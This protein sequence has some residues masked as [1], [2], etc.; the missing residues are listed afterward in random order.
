MSMNKWEDAKIV[1][2]LMKDNG[3][4]KMPASSIVEI[5]GMMNEFLIG[6]KYHPNS[7]ERYRGLKR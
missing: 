4:N 3:V 2:K 1:R 5:N 7:K 6:D